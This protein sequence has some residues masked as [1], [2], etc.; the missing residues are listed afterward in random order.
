MRRLCAGVA[1]GRLM[2]CLAGPGGFVGVHRGDVRALVRLLRV[3]WE[4]C[5]QVD[6]PL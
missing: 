1:V 5:R 3:A 6:P 2:P 4:F